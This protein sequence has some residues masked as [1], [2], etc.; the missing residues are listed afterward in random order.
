MG[1]NIGITSRPNSARGFAARF[2]NRSEFIAILTLIPPPVDFG[3][4]NFSLDA[5]FIAEPT[6][7][8]ELSATFECDDGVSFGLVVAM[9]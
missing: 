6:I 3:V 8:L 4:I 9:S 2:Y 7:V 1:R 5:E